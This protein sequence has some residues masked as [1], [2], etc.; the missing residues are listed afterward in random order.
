MEHWPDPRFRDLT[1]D[2]L[3]AISADEVADAIAQHVALRMADSGKDR[4]AVVDALPP[5]TRAIYATWLVD[6]EVNQ[7]G[8]N[9]YF[10][11]SRGVLAGVAL[12]GYELLGVEDY[13]AVMRSAI[14]THE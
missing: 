2:L 14:A 11:N 10:H 13:A 5:G 9:Q 6:N 8:F 3:A 12:A 1:P 7:G 4:L